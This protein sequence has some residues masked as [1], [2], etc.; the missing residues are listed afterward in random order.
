MSQDYPVVWEP[1]PEYVDGSEIRRFMDRHGIA[2]Y[3]ELIRRSQD[4]A[5]YWDAYVK[6]ANIAFY[7]PYTQVVD[8]TRGMPF[9]QWFV[10]GKINLAHNAL[11]K[12][13][14][15]PDT[16]GNK[17]LIW[18]GE[19]G[20]VRE[21]TFAELNAC[22]CQVANALRALGL[23]RGDRV[24]IFMPLIP[25]TI[26]GV[27]G[28][29]K[30]GGVVSPLFSGFG[31]EAV[32]VRLHS[33]EAKAVITADGCYR[34]GK[35]QPLKARLD[36]AL[37][38]APTV[39][40]VIVAERTGECPMTAG[41]DHRWKTLV[42]PQP[43]TFETVWTEAEE[44][45]I[46]S[47][48]SGTTGAPKGI[49]LPHGGVAVKIAEVSFLNARPQPGDVR[50][51]ITDF[52][53]VMG[54]GSMLGAYSTGATYLIYE[55]SLVYPDPNRMYRMIEK[56]RITTFG[57][58][59]T[60]LRALKTYASDGLRQAD[61]SSLRY[62]LHTAEPID[63]DTWLWFFEWGKRR[64]PIINIS[65]GTELFGEILCST[66]NHPHK[67][68]CLGLTP[69]VGVTLVDDDL[70]PVP[71]G[72]PGY[73]CFT[74]PQPAQTRGFWKEDERR[75]LDTYF[76]HGPDLWWHSDLA[77]QDE[78]GFWFHRGRA[79]DVLK[80][81]GRRTGPGEIEGVINE[82][83]GVLESA[84][85]GVPHDLKGEDTVAFVV[86]TP[87]SELSAEALQAH[88]IR[89]LGR[90]FALGHIH[91]V[92]ELPKTRTAKIVRRLIK[93]QYLNEPPGDVSGLANPDAL[94]RL[95][96]AP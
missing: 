22:A 55:G 69:A 30:M 40:A 90:P 35:A 5:W 63:R 77:V 15:N 17:A 2:D 58:P 81:S 16:A 37:A 11:D 56:H 29:Y 93:R 7:E 94:A 33:L 1:T 65:G 79:D 4:I 95:P 84:V 41:R 32:G 71:P 92:D 14:A 87:G 68:T 75:Y 52:G 53:W 47:Y 21:Y 8:L 45:C 50:F 12:W 74:L 24:A 88:V 70:Q 10:G 78:E 82:Y 34:N 64:A 20:S 31:P 72:Q 3:A 27:F 62:L 23:E 91:I 42:D 54:Q 38:Y 49:V 28:V 19:D 51:Q 39:E 18:E 67:P 86:P 36:E 85:I 13:A 66:I 60:A 89:H 6:F 96:R 48:S 9:P 26:I 57:A 59:A 76:P 83:P 61:L 44:T 46:V 43:A 73:L 80:I 25:E